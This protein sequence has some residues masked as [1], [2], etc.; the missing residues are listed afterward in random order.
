MTQIDPAWRQADETRRARRPRLMDDWL[1]P[2]FEGQSGALVAAMLGALI[3]GLLG[4]G[5]WHWGEFFL[6]CVTGA[7]AALWVG[8]GL[9][10]YLSLGER[11]QISM[12]VLLGMVALPIARGLI[13][14][15]RIWRDRAEEIGNR[16]I[17]FL[18]GND[19]RR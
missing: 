7:V 16:F 11:A 10:E 1:K 4:P 2:L 13:G 17:D 8:P 12:A 6:A 19:R 9:A 3:R 14:I 5:Q 15:A 18:S